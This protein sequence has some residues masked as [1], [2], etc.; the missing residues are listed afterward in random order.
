MSLF[1]SLPLRRRR[2]SFQCGSVFLLGLLLQ[3]VQAGPPAALAP[4]QVADIVDAAAT[5]ICSNHFASDEG[6]RIAAALQAWRAA[7][8]QQRF[9]DAELTIDPVAPAQNRPPRIPP[10]PG[11]RC[12]ARD[13]RAGCRDRPR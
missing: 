1:S 4:A 12:T 9:T 8:P 5:Q 11:R 7:R 3:P 10:P 2:N 13:W 6:R